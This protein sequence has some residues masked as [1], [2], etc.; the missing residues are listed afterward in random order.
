MVGMNRIIDVLHNSD[1]SIQST[2]LSGDNNSIN[3]YTEKDLR[4][5]LDDNKGGFFNPM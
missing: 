4:D 1:N 3:K 5:A 2:S